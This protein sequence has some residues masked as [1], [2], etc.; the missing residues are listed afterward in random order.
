MSVAN[1]A[2]QPHQAWGMARCA[3]AVLLA[4]VAQ[5]Y[6]AEQQFILDGLLLYSVA[7]A[8]AYR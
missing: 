2:R 8:I 7:L 5:G 3:G 1:T 4:I 6:I